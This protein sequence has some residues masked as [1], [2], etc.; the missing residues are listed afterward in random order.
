M[1][2]QGWVISTMVYRNE[3]DITTWLD[4][5][6]RSRARI[7]RDVLLMAMMKP[8]YMRWARRYYDALSGSSYGRDGVEMR[9]PDRT[10]KRDLAQ[11]LSEGC[12]L[13]VYMGHGRSRGWSGYRGFRWADVVAFEPVIPV[14]ALISL[15]CSSLRL[16]KTQSIPTGLSWVLSGRACTYLGA[17]DSVEVKPLQRIAALLLGALLRVEVTRLGDVVRYTDEEVRSQN[18]PAL[19]RAWERF[20]LIGNPCQ[21][22]S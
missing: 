8:L 3:R 4:A 1:C 20:R 11:R 5:L 14:G 18:E 13:A 21:R 12:A 17:C 10:T 7:P 22:L 16:D 2:L 19:E 15:S 6:D 9:L